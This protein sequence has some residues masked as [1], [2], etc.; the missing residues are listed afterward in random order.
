MGSWMCYIA[1]TGIYL[2]VQVSWEQLGAKGGS[3]KFM[4][5]IQ[6]GTCYQ[7]KDLESQDRVLIYLDNSRM[8]CRTILRK[9]LMW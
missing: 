4:Q 9:K 7:L 2:Q 8:I 1:V 6:S 5:M 3:L